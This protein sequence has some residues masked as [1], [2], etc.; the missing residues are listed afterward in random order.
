MAEPIDL[1]RVRAAMSLA[2]REQ[3]VLS[4]HERVTSTMDV[5]RQLASEGA[6]DGNVVIAGEQ[7]AGRGRLGRAW[8]SAPRENLY[9]TLIVRPELG[10]LRQLAMLTP[11]AIAEGVQDVVPIVP[12]IK[13]PNDVQI[14][15]LKCAGVL[16]D[17]DLHGDAPASVL[18]GVG[19]NVN[20]DPATVPELAGVA[21]CLASCAGHTVDR[22]R[23]LAAVLERFHSLCVAVRAGQSVRDRWRDRLSTLGQMVQIRS[24]DR[25]ESGLVEDVDSG[26]SLRLRRA[27]GSLA[28]I[29]AGE[30]T[31][32]V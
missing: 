26:G 10:L 16:I 24:G 18:V 30:V 15:G 7:T 27:D 14:D 22:E 21:T 20:F 3:F 8:V 25:V 29:A 1:D 19:I 4:Y 11:L 12:A 28:L 17:A 31:L 6:V 2:V 23:V 32:R 9:F 5:A 13:W